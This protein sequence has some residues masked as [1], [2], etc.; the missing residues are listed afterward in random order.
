M[1]VDKIIEPYLD[2]GNL[3]LIDR[4]PI[5]GLPNIDSEKLKQLTQKNVQFMFN[6]IAALPRKIVKDATC[7]QV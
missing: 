4:D 3:L 7:V 6:K 1:E 5:E 2:L